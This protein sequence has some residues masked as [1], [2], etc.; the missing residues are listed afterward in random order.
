[1]Y[2]NNVIYILSVTDYKS[3]WRLRLLL[4]GIYQNWSV[5]GCISCALH[6]IIHNIY[7]SDAFA[8]FFVLFTQ[9][10]GIKSKW[11]QREK[12]KMKIMNFCSVQWISFHNVY[13]LD[14]FLLKEQGSEMLDNKAYTSVLDKS[15]CFLF[16]WMELFFFLFRFSSEKNDTYGRTNL[17]LLQRFQNS[18]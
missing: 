14:V 2:I 9:Y 11:K 6:V 12:K 15:R 17:V 16:T 13:I 3:Y 5:R 10:Y 4:T 7:N 18:L 1:M 8:V